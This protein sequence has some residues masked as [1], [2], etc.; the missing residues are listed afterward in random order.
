[1]EEVIE[2]YLSAA[3]GITVIW[4]HRSAYVMTY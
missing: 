3:L 2:S 4:S 1:M